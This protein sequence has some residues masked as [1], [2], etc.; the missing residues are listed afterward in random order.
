M[1]EVEKQ[2]HKLST[3]K[4]TKNEFTDIKSNRTYS[5]YE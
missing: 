2:P 3:F 5:Y 4:R 1:A